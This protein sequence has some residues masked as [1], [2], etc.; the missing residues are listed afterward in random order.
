MPQISLYNRYGT[1]NFNSL[2]YCS[3]SEFGCS[4]SKICETRVMT[5]DVVEGIH[6]TS[7]T[8]PSCLFY[9]NLYTLC[10]SNIT[11]VYTFCFLLFFYDYTTNNDPNP[12]SLK[13][14]ILPSDFNKAYMS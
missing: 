2:Y 12:S 9:G 11:I 4:I 6:D 8:I 10:F 5:R 3:W 1:F 14:T 13:L 7:Y